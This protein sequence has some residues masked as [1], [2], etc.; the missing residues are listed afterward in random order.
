MHPDL[1]KSKQGEE[2]RE[3]KVIPGWSWIHMEPDD[4]SEQSGV[5]PQ[6]SLLVTASRGMARTEEG[7]SWKELEPPEAAHAVSPS[8]R[9]GAEGDGELGGGDSHGVRRLPHPPVEGKQIELKLEG[10][11]PHLDG[12]SKGEKKNRG[13]GTQPQ[14][15]ERHNIERGRDLTGSRQE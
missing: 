4:G 11:E 6:S 3:W 9:T 5:G 14:E 15:R 13:A 1:V 8:R 10:A 2:R 12:K 7:G